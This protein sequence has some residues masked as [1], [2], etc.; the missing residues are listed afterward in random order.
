[1]QLSWIIVFFLNEKSSTLISNHRR[2]RTSEAFPKQIDVSFVPHCH[3]IWESYV[4][5]QQVSDRYTVVGFG[6]PQCKQ[7]ISRK[8][9]F[10]VSVP[11]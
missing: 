6:L 5:V 7:E 9:A 10:S 11:M 2:D 4:S 1:M 8:N 3:S